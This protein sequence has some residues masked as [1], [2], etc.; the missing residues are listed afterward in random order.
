MIGEIG[1]KTME[2]QFTFKIKDPLGLHLRP[3][4]DMAQVFLDK[5]VEVHLTFETQK[6]NAKSPL[7]LLTLAAPCESVMTLDISG[8][9][10][11][12]ALHSF[13]EKFQDWMEPV[14]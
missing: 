7:S 11:Q 3:A 13:C 1:E 9:D 12:E 14:S 10:Q 8:I 4:K 2:T 6:V 5:A